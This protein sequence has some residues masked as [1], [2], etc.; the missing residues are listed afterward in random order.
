MTT[1][2]NK[3]YQAFEA[4]Q[5]KIVSG[6]ILAGGIYVSYRLGK[7]LLAVLQKSDAQSKADDSPEVRQA[8]ALRSAIN[9]SGISWMKSFDTTDN[10]LVFNTAKQ[11][12][13]LDQVSKSYKNLYQD[14]LL[15]DL[16]DDLSGSDFQKFLSMVS[17]SPKKD[18]SSGGTPFVQWARPNQ[19]VVAIKQV[20]LRSSPDAS[21]HGK[22]YEQF[23]P[24]NI[25]KTANPGEFLGY[26]TGKQHFDEKNNV[27]FIELAYVINGAKSPPSLKTQNKKRVSYWVSSSA[28]YVDIYTYYKQM[29]DTWPKTSAFTAWMKP[30]DFFTLKGLSMPV[31]LTKTLTPVLDDSLKAVN[32][33]RPYII[34]GQ[35]IMQLDTGNKQFMQFRTIDNQVRWVDKQYISLQQ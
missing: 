20:Q 23:S 24:K 31:L 2:K 34:L 7:K 35:L 29:F 21:Y 26:A 22:I 10:S 5:S 19:M 16:Q 12:T 13:N 25:I 27:K 17:S 8:M 33:V 1:S 9:P 28:N 32:Y 3:T 15:D 11:I 18:T 4:P 6:L 14:N 30:M